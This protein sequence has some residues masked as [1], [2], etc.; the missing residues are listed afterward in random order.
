MSGGGGNAN[1]ATAAP[2]VDPLANL[3]NEL[4]LFN[5]V[6]GPLGFEGKLFPLFLGRGN[7]NEVRADPPAFDD[8]V[9]DS[10]VREAEMPRGLDKGGVEDGILDDDLGHVD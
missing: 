2:D 7:G 6:L 4:V 5:T 9:G 3:V 8:F 10:F 1:I